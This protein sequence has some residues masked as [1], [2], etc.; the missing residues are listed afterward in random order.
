VT[1][2]TFN[3]AL[4][5]PSAQIGLWILPEVDGLFVRILLFIAGLAILGGNLGWGTLAFAL[6]IGPIVHVTI[7]RLMV[8]AAIT[9]TADETT[10]ESIIR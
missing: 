10:P 6:L 7:P 5:G 1:S 4:V 2:A 8:P 3:V 9:H